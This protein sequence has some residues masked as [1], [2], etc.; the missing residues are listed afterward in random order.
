MPVTYFQ[1]TLFY[2]PPELTAP[3]TTAEFD[4]WENNLFATSTYSLI[5]TVTNIDTNVVVRLDGTIDGTNWGPLISNTITVNGTYHYNI[6]GAPVK[7]VRG[8][9]LQETG[10]TNAVV[11]MSISA[12]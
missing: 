1:D 11:K 5:V 2:T 6:V 8:N 9:F 12:R 10:G 7:K 3:G 4:V